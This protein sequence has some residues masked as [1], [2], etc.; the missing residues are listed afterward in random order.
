MATA[1]GTD[2]LSSV[3]DVFR[4]PR[5]RLAHLALVHRL[6]ASLAKA[7]ML[8]QLDLRAAPG[9][10]R[11]EDLARLQEA[12]ARSW[13]ARARAVL[14]GTHLRSSDS[15]FRLLPAA[16]VRQVLDLVAEE[17]RCHVAFAVEAPLVFDPIDADHVGQ[18]PP[19]PT[20]LVLG[21]GF[22]QQM[23]QGG[24]MGFIAGMLQ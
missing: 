18:Q 9:V 19:I 17:S 13:N 24:D 23:Q 4:P 12:A 11:S 8:A 15:P 1:D 10:L 16:L 14:M 2:P 6:A 3:S 22:P 20:H 21:Q 5:L 7:T